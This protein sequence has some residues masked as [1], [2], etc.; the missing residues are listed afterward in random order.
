MG[1]LAIMSGSENL[2]SLDKERLNILGMGGLVVKAGLDDLHRLNKAALL[3]LLLE[4]RHKL[5]VSDKLQKKKL[6]QNYTNIGVRAFFG[7]NSQQ[8]VMVY[9][10]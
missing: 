9:D 7:N 10:E 5:E 8:S 3:G 1:T 4:A 2:V 6:L